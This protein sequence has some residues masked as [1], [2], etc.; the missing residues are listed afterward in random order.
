MTGAKASQQSTPKNQTS[1][2]FTVAS[3]TSNAPI[4][5][6]STV[7]PCVNKFRD[8]GFPLWKNEGY[9]PL[10]KG[11]VSGGIHS[12]ATLLQNQNQNY[13]HAT[14]TSD[15]DDRDN[16][17]GQLT[18]CFATAQHLKN[19]EASTSSSTTAARHIG[20]VVG[21]RTADSVLRDLTNTNPE[22]LSQERCNS[23]GPSSRPPYANTDVDAP[24]NSNKD[25]DEA[26]IEQSIEKS[27]A[28]IT[29]AS[30]SIERKRYLL[31][32]VAITLQRK[33]E[34]YPEIAELVDSVRSFVKKTDLGNLG[35]KFPFLVRKLDHIKVRLDQLIRPSVAPAT[36]EEGRKR[37]ALSAFGAGEHEE[38]SL[39]KH[40]PAKTR[41][42]GRKQWSAD[43]VVIIDHNF[44]FATD[45]ER[46]P[47]K[48][49]ENALVV[50]TDGSFCP[51][52]RHAGAG[53]AWQ[54][55][56][57]DADGFSSGE[58][59][60][61]GYAWP[62]GKDDEISLSNFSEL[63]AIKLAL[64]MIMDVDIL[65]SRKR[66]V[67]QTDSRDALVRIENY[68]RGKN[69]SSR[70]TGMTVSRISELRSWGVDIA[71]VWVK[72][73]HCCAGNRIADVLA[74]HGRCV[75]EQGIPP[76][77]AFDLLF[78]HPS[79]YSQAEM[80]GYADYSYI[81]S[82]RKADHDASAPAGPPTDGS[83]LSTR[84]I[85]PQARSA[86]RSIPRILQGTSESTRTTDGSLTDSVPAK[87][88]TSI[89][90]VPDPPNEASG[91]ANAQGASFS[92]A[93]QKKLQ[94]HL[95]AT[96]QL[97]HFSMASSVA[98]PSASSEGLVEKNESQ[99]FKGHPRSGK[100][101]YWAVDASE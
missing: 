99:S 60:W 48:V 1:S 19:V 90:T 32:K 16:T 91:T 82:S 86:A 20:D 59:K 22:S 15:N 61:N 13:S 26:L 96:T 44:G 2:P 95:G 52:T 6:Q 71:F 35:E 49:Y 69:T 62:L 73:H 57:I 56:V 78:S 50:S 74:G 37:K 93:Q 29:R 17:A 8:L 36:A 100:R 92:T 21:P 34:D 88:E 30:F 72:G 63:M 14:R 31:L 97:A 33:G 76:V 10:G 77:T 41:D 4:A 89:V 80:R 11:P 47:D 40:K 101:A 70:T 42:C 39:K 64:E 12:N 85:L 84:K 45:L 3:N 18:Q 75:S 7:P 46:G 38:P 81:P 87:T 65:D 83:Q 55:A 66:A 24:E 58:M 98:E 51:I 9:T 54:T 28:S 43:L 68:L 53:T 23:R 67:I 79:H 25:S 5:Q 94:N 27:S